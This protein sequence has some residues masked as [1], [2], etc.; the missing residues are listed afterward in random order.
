MRNS[1]LNAAR[2]NYRY[3]RNFWARLIALLP[4][5]VLDMRRRLIEYL[6]P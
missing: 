1:T 2:R 6:H 4:V 3:G 5:I